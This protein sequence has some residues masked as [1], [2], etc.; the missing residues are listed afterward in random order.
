MKKIIHH[1]HVGFIPGIQGFFN[2]RKSIN[3]MHHIYK[4]RDKIHRIISIDAE[5]AFDRI[6]HPF[7]LK[8]LKE[9]TVN[10]ELPKNERKLMTLLNKQKV[11]E[12]IT[13]L[14]LQEMILQYSQ[15]NQRN[16]PH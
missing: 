7:M 9:S 5:K 2:I 12:F 6:Q 1:D 4:L 11:K 10:Q 3:V 13:R 14:T 16:T 8:H 15:I